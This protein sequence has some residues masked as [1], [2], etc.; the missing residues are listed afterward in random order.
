MITLDAM[1]TIA[2]I[3]GLRT[4]TPGLDSALIL[5]TAA[6]RHRRRARGVALGIQSGTC[7]FSWPSSG[8][9]R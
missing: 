1:V 8:P 6:L 3:V 7:T 2:L 5:R 4:L 9:V